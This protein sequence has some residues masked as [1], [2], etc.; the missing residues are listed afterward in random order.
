LG[1]VALLNEAKKLGVQ[2]TVSDEGDF[3]ETRSLERLTKEIGEQSTMLAGFLGA[4][5][6]AMDQAPGG[7]GTVEAPIAAY[8]NFEHLESE[9]QRLLPEQLKTM[10]KALS[11][12]GLSTLLAAATNGQVR[13]WVGLDPVDAGQKGAAAA[14]GSRIPCAVLLAEPCHCNANG[15][16]KQIAAGLSGPLFALR[17]RNPTHTTE[18]RLIILPHLRW[19]IPGR[20]AWV[21]RNIDLRLTFRTFS[22]SC[23]V[24]SLKGSGRLMPALFARM[25]MLPSP[26][27]VKAPRPSRQNTIPR[28]F[29]IR[30]DLP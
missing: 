19:R 5:K 7:T 28:R 27:R 26:L 4:L 8:P 14:K 15:N 24:I 11:M 6:D 2:G 23:S 3:W 1:V 22:Q 13:C 17:V 21:T 29:T 16:A 20:T 12:G 30:R 25:S 18:D 9:G 10:L